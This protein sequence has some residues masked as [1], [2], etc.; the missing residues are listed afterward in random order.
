MH[1]IHKPFN[2][3]RKL[4]ATRIKFVKDFRFPSVSRSL[5][6]LS[7]KHTIISNKYTRE[8]ISSYNTRRELPPSIFNLLSSF[9]SSIRLS[10]V[11]ITHQVK[12]NFS[13]LLNSEKSVVLVNTMHHVK[14]ELST[15]SPSQFASIHLSQSVMLLCEKSSTA[16]YT[17]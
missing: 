11:D 15:F 4:T 7:V 14:L 3:V 1:E 9:S 17:R 8:L 13:K 10:T 16:K 12:I 5:N 2:K 6:S